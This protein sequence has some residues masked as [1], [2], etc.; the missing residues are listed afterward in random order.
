LIGKTLAHYEITGLL[1]KG[2]M[3]E[4]FRA[5]DSRLGRDVALKILPQDISE[6]PNRRERFRREALAVA[7][8]KHPNIVTLYSA[9]EHQGTQFLT[10]ELVEGEELRSVLRP[11]GLAIE[12]LFDLAIPLTQAIASAHEKGITH[13]DLKPSNILLDEEQRPKILDFGL[14]QIIEEVAEGDATA[15]VQPELT[16]DGTVIGT[17]GYMAPEQAEGKPTDHR[18]DIFSLGVILYELATGERPF[19]GDTSASILTSL[20]RDEPPSVIEVRADLPDHLGRIVRRCLAKEPRDRYQSAREL[21]NELRDLRTEVTVKRHASKG[22]VPRGGVGRFLIPVA[23]AALVGAIAIAT[24]PLLRE[25]GPASTVREAAEAI[26]IVVLP[27]EN[28]GNPDDEFFA[29]GMT[30]EVTNR[31]ASVEGLAVIS[32]RSAETYAN[33]DVPLRQIGDELGVEYALASTV[34]WART[35]D[36]VRI[37]VSPQLVRVA[38]DTQLWSNVYDRTFEDVFTI[39][40]GIALDVIREL[41]VALIGEDSSELEEI[42]TR[43]PRAHEL[44]LRAL[45]NSGDYGKMVMDER[46][47]LLE[48]AVEADPEFARAWAV[49][50]Q[51]KSVML[52]IGQ[53]ASDE[54]LARARY[55]KDRALALAPDAAFAQV[56]AGFFHYHGL[57][58]YAAA[59]AAFA[60]AAE[61]RPN[62]T[63][64]L[65]G[66][67]L[68]QRRQGQWG[69]STRNFQAALD[70]NPRDV[71]LLVDLL[72][73]Y[74]AGSRW[75]ET[76]ELIQIVRSM[77]PNV[78]SPNVL[79]AF[80]YICEDGNLPEARRSVM[81]VADQTMTW[82]AETLG[83]ID[84]Y[85]GNYE[86]ALT[87]IARARNP[88]M[89]S[90]ATVR[91]GAV[92]RGLLHRLAGNEA[93]A[94]GNLEFAVGQLERIIATRA[95]GFRYESALGIVHAA[96][97]NEAEAR[98]QA[99]RALE[100]FPLERDFSWGPGLYMDVAQIYTMI[101]DLDLALINAEIALSWPCYWTPQRIALDPWL[102]ALADHPDYE[103]MT[104]RAAEKRAGV[105]RDKD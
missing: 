50:A 66:L 75:T 23:A 85:S 13:R 53:I 9:E 39:Q 41:G 32:S 25:R 42:P 28:L 3:G 5:R 10:M 16:T 99:E 51:S 14:A 30:E 89:L 38:D 96:L 77:H 82:V 97:G 36:S 91:T 52:H 81:S 72:D 37:R 34:R 68:V 54:D 98:Y 22:V 8:L 45:A 71:N 60:R 35:G 104:R 24:I 47:R 57:K 84:M 93:E 87:E 92:W 7:A 43:V 18:S 26:R 29:A 55:A 40:S 49:L 94:R 80:A 19:Q 102:K 4:V 1:G 31:L 21:H 100:Q 79:A 86:S 12:F 44:Y 90:G 95:D 59:E 83:L 105:V 58:D 2:G 33:R 63:E 15:I 62:D 64:M 20:L 70:L 88:I 73:S 69:E 61:K 56:A 103:D 78:A 11:D 46:V 67:A 27:M 74:L 101:G 48:E 76:W 6:D 17:V 65:R